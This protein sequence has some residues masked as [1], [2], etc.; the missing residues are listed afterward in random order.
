MCRKPPLTRFDKAKS[1]RRYCP[2]ERHRR[3]RPLPSQRK[4]AVTFTAGEDDR[5][6]MRSIFHTVSRDLTW[7]DGAR[8]KTST[9][10]GGNVRSI[11]WCRP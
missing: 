3:F 9:L 1:I 6:D 2:P 8:S 10:S 5:K 11:E 7:V 4:Q